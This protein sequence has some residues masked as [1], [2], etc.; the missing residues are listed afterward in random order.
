MKRYH[1]HIPVVLIEDGNGSDENLV[2]NFCATPLQT[3]LTC[4]G[5]HQ[6]RQKRSHWHKKMD[7]ETAKALAE[8]LR[9]KDQTPNLP[10]SPESTY[11]SLCYDDP[12]VRDHA[13]LR[14]LA[15]NLHKL[16]LSR[17]FVDGLLH[18][19]ERVP[20]QSN[21]TSSGNG[22][23]NLYDVRI[24]NG[25][26]GGELVQCGIAEVI[27]ACFV[28][29]PLELLQQ[30][31]IGRVRNFVGNYSGCLD[32][33]EDL[34][35]SN[36]RNFCYSDENVASTQEL[37]NEYAEIIADESDESDCEYEDGHVYQPS[38]TV[39]FEDP[40]SFGSLTRMPAKPLNW[41]ELRSI[42][43]ELMSRFD[44]SHIS[45]LDIETWRTLSASK[46]LTDITLELLF[47]DFSSND[48]GKTSLTSSS[49]FKSVNDF[50]ILWQKYLFILRDRVLDEK[51]NKD[52][53]DAFV[54]FIILIRRVVEK[55]SYFCAEEETVIMTILNC[56]ASM[57]SSYSIRNSTR[58][59]FDLSNTLNSLL[60][61][62]TQLLERIRKNDSLHKFITPLCSVLE[63]F[64][65]ASLK[66]DGNFSNPVISPQLISS[67]FFIE[68]LVVSE[69]LLSQPT[70]KSHSSR[71]VVRSI[72]FLCAQS[73]NLLNFASSRSDLVEKLHDV[74]F[75][76]KNLFESLI[77]SLLELQTI[78][79]SPKLKLIS[80]SKSKD[81]E[82]LD[83]K[84]DTKA[85]FVE[86]FSILHDKVNQLL[87][88][89]EDDRINLSVKDDLISF[90]NAISCNQHLSRSL[91]A[92]SQQTNDNI[93]SR[94]SNLLKSITSWKEPKKTREETGLTIVIVDSMRKAVKNL[95]LR[96]TQE[97][98]ICLPSSRTMHNNNIQLRQSS[99][100]D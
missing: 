46:I 10:A 68:M 96:I 80:M 18:C 94:L 69:M 87:I 17:P 66:D 91:R 24:S 6:S 81:K 15:M 83:S 76:N 57:C 98:I 13:S 30:D 100:N 85:K 47:N 92:L 41:E 14:K 67:R 19:A 58:K 29:I 86:C 52:D 35:E 82:K 36:H 32:K 9:L 21:D 62:L 42:M 56:L 59:H 40:F 77:W 5:R 12:I 37:C 4:T 65:G 79:K 90:S 28:R 49:D 34:V 74:S 54:A 43:K 8:A 26:G 93:Q 78:S 71:R 1:C 20:S 48:R 55:R 97:D 64:A 27:F 23:S 45:A 25:G 63:F 7:R 44:Y 75:S 2:R 3:R 99:K 51:V 33:E 60:P 88:Q 70:A 73:E 53:V 16:P 22:F 61:W 95:L 72:I 38:S 11:T 31:D 84:Y 39:S 89:N 50:S